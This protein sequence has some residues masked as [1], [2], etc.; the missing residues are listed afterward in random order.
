MGQNN[1][2]GDQFADESKRMYV[3]YIND[4]GIEYYLQKILY[5]AAGDDH[6]LQ[7]DELNSYVDANPLSWRSFAFI[8]NMLTEKCVGEDKLTKADVLQ[9]VG[10]LRYLRDFS[11]VAER[12]IEETSLW[13]DY[14]VYASLYGIADQVRKD[15][16]KVAPDV[17]SL[18]QFKLT[19]DV[20]SDFEPLRTTLAESLAMA[21][22]Y[23]TTEER[24]EYDRK[25][26]EMQDSSDYGGSGSSSYGGGGGHSGGGGSGFR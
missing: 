12:G 11:L 5:E 26:A 4:A 1:F 18:D 13:K 24:V 23:A 20:V 16:K 17:A 22:R 7:P 21:F 3:G 14:L 6:L 2:A 15:M 19:E 9:V 8:L 10:F 25:L